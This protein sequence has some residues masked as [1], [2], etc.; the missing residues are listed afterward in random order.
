MTFNVFSDKLQ[1]LIQKKGFLE[2][3]LPQKM[4]IPHILEGKDVLIIAPTGSGK[5]EAACLPLFDKIVREHEEPISILYINPLRSLSRDLLDRLFWWADKLDIEVAVRHGDTTQQERKLQSES[6]PHC[7]ITTPETL[8]SIL[9]GK[10][11]R[12]HLSHV[13]Y[14]IVD[15]IHEIV[16]NKRGV[17][18]SLLLERLKQVAGP[19][20]RIGIS[21]T[22][23][24]PQKVAAFLSPQALIV[25]A[26][27]AKHYDIRVEYPKPKP[28]HREQAAQLFI[29]DITLARMLRLKELIESHTSVIT[30]TNTRETAEILSSRFRALDKELKQEVH[31]GSLSKESRIDSEQKFK[32]QQLKS[33][34]ATSSLE[35]GI[36]IGSIDLV[37]QY[38]SPRQVSKLIQRVGR[39]GHRIT[40]KSKGIILSGEEDLF[41]SAVIARKA[42]SGE[43]EEIR[44]HDMALDVL[45]T[46]IIGI[47]LER[48]DVTSTEV[49]D[50]VKNAYPYRNLTYDQFLTVLKFLGSL[51]LLW[52]RELTDNTLAIRRSRRSWEHYYENLSMIPD[53]RQTKIISIVQNEPI[54]S[55]DEAFLAEHG[56]PGSSFICK[57]RAWRVLRA[58]EGKVIVEPVIDMDSAIPA[59]E[60]ELIPVPASIAAEVGVLRQLASRGDADTIQERYNVDKHCLDELIAIAAKSDVVPHSGAFLLEHHKDFIILHTC[61]GTLVNDT[62]GR[63]VAA[64]LTAETGTSVNMKTDPYRIIFQCHAS[65]KDIKRILEHAD[66]LKETLELAIERSTLFK[67]RFLHASRRFGIISRKARFD[68]LGLSRILSQYAGTPVYHETMREVLVDKMDLD[69]AQR[70]LDKIKKKEIRIQTSTTL[71]HFGELG[72]SRHFSEVMKPAMP[73]SEIFEAFK[74]RVL[75]TTIRLTCTNCAD[76][77]ILSD[78]QDAAEQPT[79]PKCHSGFI[80]VSNK[81]TNPQPL[82][83]RHKDKKKLSKEEQRNVDELK[84]SASLVMT[85]GKRYVMVQAGHGIGVETAAR[86]LARLPKDDE[87]LLKYIFEAEKLYARTRQYWK[88]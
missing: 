74:R 42:L 72:L 58:E 87:Q 78:V 75:K 59:W 73:G 55:L 25:N 77:T 14:V 66:K 52:L 41:E 26:V 50:I 18:L 9:I 67:Y 49:Y 38:L 43:I 71:S 29:S 4:G 6:P 63:Y 15:E 1:K 51:R 22:V 12:K 8:A 30:F 10:N 37:V 62:I 17:Q 60:G 82:L 64:V 16:E 33:L 84:R 65:P 47:C 3:T 31:H 2:P 36:D 7:L 70:I 76:F 69:E 34:I 85:Y 20:Q 61:C 83:R 57:G 40:Q 24:D 11:M 44:V 27:G 19:F 81:Y 86:V 45:A 88:A 23:G 35:L 68:R 54:G 79:C 39:A 46:Q 32:K 21:A 48:Y 56:E 5:T 80:A 53:T 13:R 28:F